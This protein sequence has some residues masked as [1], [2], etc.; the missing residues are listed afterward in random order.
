VPGVVNVRST[1][2]RGVADVS[3]NF[4]WGIDMASATL[5]VNANGPWSK[6]PSWVNV[7][8]LDGA[9]AGDDVS[10][11]IDSH[12]VHLAQVHVGLLV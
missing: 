6:L 5:Q 1:T 4:T 7:A 2:S 8:Q 3:I 12:A 10:V 11:L 9:H